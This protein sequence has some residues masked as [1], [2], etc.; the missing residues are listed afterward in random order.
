MSPH[1]ACYGRIF[2]PTLVRTDNKEIRGKVF[3]YLVEHTGVVE[4]GRTVTTDLQAWEECTLC[5][6][7]ESCFRLSTGTVLMELALK[8]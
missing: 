3:G 2:P 4:R 5:P 7:P 1:S 6:D 8:G